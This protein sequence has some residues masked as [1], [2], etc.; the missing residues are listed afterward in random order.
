MIENVF[1]YNDLI[2]KNEDPLAFLIR[3]EYFELLRLAFD[4]LDTLGKFLILE[5]AINKESLYI[6]SQ[7]LNLNMKVAYKKYNSSLRFIRR[8]LRFNKIICN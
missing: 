6:I 3:S 2:Y 1:D 7:L 4:N 8:I 5:I